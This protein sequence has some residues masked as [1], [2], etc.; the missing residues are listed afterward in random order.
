MASAHTALE[1]ILLK[2][3]WIS[4]HDL[5]R[6]HQYRKRGQS[7]ADSLIEIRVIEPRR[8]AYALSEAF[9]LPLQ[10]HLDEGT[11]DGQQLTKIGIS[12]ARKNRTLPLG[13]DGAN[14]VV[15]VADPSRYEPLDDLG[16]LFGMPVQQVIVPFDVLDCAIE[17]SNGQDGAAG[18][19]INLEEQQLEPAARQLERMPLDLLNPEAPPLVRLVTALLWRAVNDRARDIQIEPLERISLVRFRTDTALYDAMSLPRC[20]EGMLTSRLKGLAGISVA[21]GRSPQSGHIRLRIAGRVVAARVSTM[22]GAFG[23]MIVLRL[24]DSKHE[25]VDVIEDFVD[26]LH[27]LTADTTRPLCRHCGEP[28]VVARALFCKNCGTS[29]TDSAGLAQ[30]GQSGGS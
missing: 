27:G 5:K 23:E 2:H 12:Y 16:V 30:V 6:A 21:A 14:V 25:L 28:I 9:C 8:L 18:M 4:R 10:T 19:I 22:P 20:L 11:I 1:T 15:A 26:A 17:C 24:P 29:L 13:T 7:L 3:S